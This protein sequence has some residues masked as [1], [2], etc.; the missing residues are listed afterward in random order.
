MIFSTYP[1]SCSLTQQQQE[2][3]QPSLT[4]VETLYGAWAQK[5]DKQSKVSA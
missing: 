3:Q 1:V 5:M 4:D 2:Q